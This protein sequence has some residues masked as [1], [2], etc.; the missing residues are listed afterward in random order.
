MS[1]IMVKHYLDGTSLTLEQAEREV[2]DMIA[3][4][5]DNG[6]ADDVNTTELAAIATAYY[7]LRTRVMTDVTVASLRA[8]LAQGNPVIIPAG[9][10]LLKNPYF[11][12]EGPFYHMLVVT[13]YDARGFITNDP[14]TKRGESYWY[15]TDVLMNAIHDWTGVKEEIEKGA[16][17]AL[18]VTL[19]E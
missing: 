5:R 14:G 6:Y 9:G 18:V 2:Q 13:G 4:Q 12:G 11:S 7:G 17:N 10:R 16:K 8:E 15:A 1:L 3:W 19:A